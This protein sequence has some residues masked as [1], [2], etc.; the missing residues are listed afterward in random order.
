MTMNLTLDGSSPCHFIF[1]AYFRGTCQ[2]RCVG[3]GEV[4]SRVACKHLA[5]AFLETSSSRPP[6]LGKYL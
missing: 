3:E 1:N 2:T 4:S 5:E 6:H